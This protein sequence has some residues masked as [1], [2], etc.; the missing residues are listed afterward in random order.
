MKIDKEEKLLFA[1]LNGETAKKEL[2]GKFSPEA[3]VDSLLLL[4]HYGTTDQ[5]LMLRGK[6]VLRCLWHV[7]RI[8]KLLGSLSFLPTF[9]ADFLYKHFAKHRYF[10]G[11]PPL[12]R[13]PTPSET[14]RFLP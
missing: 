13:L 12:C 11:R 10:F 1:P 2:K 7:G 5:E 8:W 4:E 3:D 6:A 14:K 9:W